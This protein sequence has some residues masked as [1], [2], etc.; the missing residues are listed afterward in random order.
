MMTDGRLTDAEALTRVSR[1]MIGV[2]LV[3]W[4]RVLRAGLLAAAVTLLVAE[5]AACLVIGSFPPP[6]IAQL[7]AGMLALA[8]GYCV[9]ATALFAL[10][11]RGGVRFIRHLEGDIT[12]GA[13][14]A[15]VFAR[16]EVGDLGAGA[17]RAFASLRGVASAKASPRPSRAR[18]ATN[19]RPPIPARAIANPVAVVAV[20]LD[21]ARLA[22]P[23]SLAADV[24]RDPDDAI[25]RTPPPAMQSLPVLAARLPRIGWTYDELS[26]PSPAATSRPT[27]APSVPLAFQAAQAVSPASDTPLTP[28][29][30]TGAP[31]GAP[32]SPDDVS[33]DVSPEDTD[34]SE[35]PETAGRTPDAPGL[36]PRGWRRSDASPRPL[37]AI[38]R[39]LPTP[40]GARSSALWARVSQAL[41][42]QSRPVAQ[43]ADAEATRDEFHAEPPPVADDVAPEDAWLNG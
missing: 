43:P 27:P 26:A 6:P 2:V 29:T 20:G 42:G 13:E 16:R 4:Q 15:S 35:A 40:S 28:T 5:I 12:I 34:E 17:R 25:I 32:L 30:G 9:A 37:P 18:P 24:R 31:T 41:V 3:S 33:D 11:L 23:R 8:V 1:Q 38:T 14:A 21:V 19:S 10:L 7:V 39:P 22:L 36:I